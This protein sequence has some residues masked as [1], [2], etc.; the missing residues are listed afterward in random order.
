MAATLS[1]QLPEAG[2]LLKQRITSSGNFVTGWI[3]QETTLRHPACVFAT[4]A[5]TE[6]NDDSF[7]TASATSSV[8]LAITPSSNRSS[9]ACLSSSG[10]SACVALLIAP[11]QT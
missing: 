7:A 4:Y 9:T 2:E 5:F 10:P 8:T 6:E 11:E 1:A 3:D